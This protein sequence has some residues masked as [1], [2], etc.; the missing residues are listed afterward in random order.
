M[1]SMPIQ[2]ATYPEYTIPLTQQ[3]VDVADDDADL[4]AQVI[5]LKD[6]RNL[7]SIVAVVVLC[8]SSTRLYHRRIL[9]KTEMF[10]I[11]K[12]N[13]H[14]LLAVCSLCSHSVLT[15]WLL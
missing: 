4:V 3:V 12:S 7:M 8:L 11:Q 14:C 1:G 10:Q 9:K 2:H 6:S 15:V 13:G 5:L